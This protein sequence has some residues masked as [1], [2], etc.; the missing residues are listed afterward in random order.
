MENLAVATGIQR[1]QIVGMAESTMKGQRV[2][3]SRIH[4][5]PCGE[6]LASAVTQTDKSYL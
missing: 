6:M 3:L 4:L 1:H 2:Q 5:Q